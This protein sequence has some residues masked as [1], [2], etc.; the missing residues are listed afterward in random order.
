M[1]QSPRNTVLSPPSRS[2]APLVAVN[3]KRKTMSTRSIKAC[4]LSGQGE[5]DPMRGVRGV[6]LFT[7]RFKL[8]LGLPSLSLA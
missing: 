1:K 2:N 4:F 8:D 6:L 3:I 7:E 5:S